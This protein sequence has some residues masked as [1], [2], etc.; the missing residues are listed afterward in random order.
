MSGVQFLTFQLNGQTYGL[1]IAAVREINR[2]AEITPVP[3][4][5]TFVV[6]VMN[7]RGK[8]M[9]VLDL[10]LRLGLP[11]TTP[12]RESCIVIVEGSEGEV[13]M[14]VDSVAE[15]IELPEETRQIP[16][17]MSADADYSTIGA[18]A[19]RDDKVILILD[20]NRTL[21]VDPSAFEAA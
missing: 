18:M 3:R 5:P 4:V 16:P 1:P 7:L 21:F 17:K 13:G 8:V 12:T 20:V 9:P 19:R 11:A 10:R 15:V 14:I 6:G 2:M